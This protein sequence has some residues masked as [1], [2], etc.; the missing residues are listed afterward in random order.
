MIHGMRPALVTRISNLPSLGMH[1]MHAVRPDHLAWWWYARVTN[2][3]VASSDTTDKRSQ[4]REE[5]HGT[6]TLLYLSLLGT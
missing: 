4:V 5:E 2:F 3:A 1:H 6:I